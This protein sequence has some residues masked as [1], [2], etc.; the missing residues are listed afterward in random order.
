MRRLSLALLFMGC[1]LQNGAA[2]THTV[3]LKWNKQKKTYAANYVVYRGPSCGHYRHRWVIP[4]T[5][6]TYKDLVGTGN[7]A[8]AVS[9]IDQFNVESKTSNCSKA[10][11]P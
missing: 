9:D 7:Y 1:C 6:L 11:V 8:Y 10:V 5:V 3:T 2:A 4:G